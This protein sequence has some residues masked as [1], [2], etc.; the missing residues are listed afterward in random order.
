MNSFLYLLSL[1]SLS[2]KHPHLSWV[3][4]GYW[5]PILFFHWIFLIFI[6]IYGRFFSHFCLFL[7]SKLG[8]FFLK[9][10]YDYPFKLEFYISCYSKGIDIYWQCWEEAKIYHPWGLVVH[11][12]P[13]LSL[14][15]RYLSTCIIWKKN[16]TLWKFKYPYFLSIMNWQMLLKGS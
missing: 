15:A 11:L 3:D 5:K 13:R 4:V 16:H 2:T 7:L 1:L 9:K 12:L 10:R 6:P 8:F 14:R